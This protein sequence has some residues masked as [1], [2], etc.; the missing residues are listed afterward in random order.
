MVRVTCPTD[1]VY[2]ETNTEYQQKRVGDRFAQARRDFYQEL[3]QLGSDKAAALFNLVEV[4]AFS[5]FLN[6][7]DGQDGDVLG[8]I[9]SLRRTLSPLHIPPTPESA[10]AER[11]KKEYE[12]FAKREP[13]QKLDSQMATDVL[14]RSLKFIT[15]FSG[16]GLQSQ[17]FIMGLIGYIRAHHPA[18][19]EHLAKQQDT[20][21]IVLPGEFTPGRAEAPGH[22]HDHPHTHP[23]HHHHEGPTGRP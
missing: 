19:A 9:Q 21:R 17:R 14:D 18:I 20:G 10:F 4:V 22:G 23:H 11:L 15:D 7:R 5:Y 12:T 8:A 16:G 6:R 13:Q 1:C 2:L 3:F